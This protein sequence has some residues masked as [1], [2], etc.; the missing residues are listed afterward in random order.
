[1]STPVPEFTQTLCTGCQGLSPAIATC[2]VCHGRGVW[3][4]SRDE[5]L[6]WGVPLDGFSFTFRRLKIRLHAIVHLVIALMILAGGIGA[7]WSFLQADGDPAH[8]LDIG[9]FLNG[10]RA[11]LLLWSSVLL[12]AFFVFRLAVYG[13][14]FK[15]LP[16]WSLS[17]R[18]RLTQK[19]HGWVTFGARVQE[20]D[21]SVYF[22][23]SA[24]QILE[25]ALDLAGQLKQAQVRPVH[26]FASALSSPAGGI[27]MRR[28]GMDFEK[29]KPGLVQLLRQG[30]TGAESVFHIET[31][32][33]LLAAYQ[34]AV[35][36]RRKSVG[37]IELFLTAFL[38]DESLRDVI[39]AA[40]YPQK[41]VT[42][43][44]EWIRTQEL[45]REQRDRF[46]H[47]ARLKPNSSMNRSMTAR[48]TE[49]LDHFSEDLTLLARNGYIAPVVGRDAELEEIFRLMD[50]GGQSVV[51]VGE[52]GTGKASLV[53]AIARR[54]VEEDVPPMFTDKRLV[55]VHVAQLITSGD[56]ASAGERLLQMMVEAG[57][58]GNIILVLHGIEALVGAGARGNLDLAETLA[59]ELDK[60]YV[61][62][63]ASTTPGA[64]AKHLER[65]SLGAKLGIVQV[66]PLSEEQT[67][68]VL[69]AKSGFIE[70]QQKVFFSY[71]ALEQTAALSSRYIR[72]IA[73]PESAIRVAT[74]SA[75]YAHATHGDYGFVSAED[76]AHIIHQ[77]TNIPVEAV[78]KDESAK[79]LALESNLHKRVIGQEQAVVAV[80]QAMRRARA[81]IREGK[82]PIANFLFL[83]PTGV[84]KTEL[85]KALGA[86]YFG[87]EQSMIRLDMSEYQD[88]SSVARIIGE[89]GDSRGGLLTEAV[90]RNPFT[91]VLLDE[92]EKA[93][94]DILTLFLQVMDD[95]RL[96]DGVGRTVD[97]TNVVLIA[98]SNAGT[99]FIQDAVASATPIEQIKTALMERELRGTFRPEFLNRFDAVI[100]FKPLTLDD[101]TQIAWLMIHSIIKRLEEKGITFR[102]EDEAVEALARAG[103]D[104]LFG[105]RPLRRVIQERVENALADILLRQ[106]VKR[107]DTLVLEADMVLRVEPF[108]IA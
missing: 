69:M 20:R 2:T 82:R 55:S 90:R 75:T 32:K 39:D 62:V 53:E 27:F 72:E 79:L 48:Q 47:L 16:E 63:I 88:R 36:A 3:L 99:Q 17:T 108:Q 56:P 97:F 86:E 29:V 70:Y 24:W 95:G 8:L 25:R 26:V 57:I 33:L 14:P 91:I 52:P 66:R 41:H 42:H 43:V 98:T 13:Q 58:S 89:P 31:R 11:A 61:R 15:I 1:M 6:F 44:A 49:L 10:S 64:W 73:L 50:G 102:A 4:A 107:K 76:V 45:L 59:Q 28:L 46:V 9:T 54:M 85:A 67:I 87:S 104:P 5:V 106:G 84:G 77:K 7:A 35:T 30:E 105:A 23:P 81:D 71:A 37:T 93:S 18:D 101:V 34:Q 60:G 94:P 68:R 78:G 92:L 21:I 38:S 74:E 65:R 100:V 12:L 19:F 40:G 22:Q 83:G 96:T 80:S 103:F 51:L